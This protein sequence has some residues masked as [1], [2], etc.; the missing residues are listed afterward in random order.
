MKKGDFNSILL[1]L[2]TIRAHPGKGNEIPITPLGNPLRLAGYIR[3][4]SELMFEVS[5]EV[6]NV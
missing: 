3:V 2:S 6:Y 5:A 4:L 1:H